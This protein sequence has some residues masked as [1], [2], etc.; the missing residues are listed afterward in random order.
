[1]HTVKGGR[2]SHLSPDS[3]DGAK[4]EQIATAKGLYIAS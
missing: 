3:W 4:L 1:M 2:H